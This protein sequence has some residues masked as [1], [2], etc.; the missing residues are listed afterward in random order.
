MAEFKIKQY[1]GVKNER[2]VLRLVHD[3][4]TAP[5][6]CTEI[7]TTH[8]SINATTVQLLS[9]TKHALSTIPILSVKV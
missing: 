3:T 1:G 7:Y 2:P 6:T 5:V 4:T 8:V 9:H